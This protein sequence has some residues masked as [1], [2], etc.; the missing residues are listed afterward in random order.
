[1]TEEGVLAL[2][3]KQA[4]ECLK[5]STSML[6]LLTKRGDIAVCQI[7]RR[8]LYRPEALRDYLSRVESPRRA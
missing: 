1:M 7:G 5:I 8:R 2:T 6:D 4:A 3:R